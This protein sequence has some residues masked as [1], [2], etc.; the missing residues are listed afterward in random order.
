M[1]VKQRE[2]EAGRKGMLVKL[3][4]EVREAEEWYRGWM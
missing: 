3:V 2:G 4:T 1:R